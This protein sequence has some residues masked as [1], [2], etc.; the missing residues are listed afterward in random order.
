MR[1][2]CNKSHQ[3]SMLFSRT[4]NLEGGERLVRGRIFDTRA[5]LE[6]IR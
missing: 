5:M 2:M 1:D 6:G 4:I 3:S